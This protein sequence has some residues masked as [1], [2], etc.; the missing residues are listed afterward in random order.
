LIAGDRFQ[1]IREFESEA[2][3]RRKSRPEHHYAKSVIVLF[4]SLSSSVGERPVGW[5]G[6]HGV[7]LLV[8]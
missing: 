1:T 3:P 2:F 7:N 4:A 5:L 8:V 6:V